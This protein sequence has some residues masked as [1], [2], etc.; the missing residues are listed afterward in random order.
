V[1]AP[2]LAN[3][4]RTTVYPDPFPEDPI[5]LPASRRQRLLFGAL[6]WSG[7]GLGLGAAGTRWLALHGGSWRGPAWAGAVAVG[8]AKGY[9]LLAPRA[10]ANAR[11]IAASDPVRPLAEAFPR[12]T[13]IL[14][15]GMMALGWT[16]RHS[17]L[18]W[19]VVGWIYTAIGAALL[20]GGRRAWEGWAKEGRG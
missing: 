9:F 2:A 1:E 15:A 16:V 11:R 19:G 18:S 4:L 14:V 12:M 3:K 5:V 6:V 7:V 10:E 17:G 13:W 8:L 20:V